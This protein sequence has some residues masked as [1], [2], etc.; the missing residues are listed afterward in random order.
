KVKVEV[1]DRL[2]RLAPAVADEAI[3]GEA[4]VA[5][6]RRRAGHELSQKG[7]V[8]GGVEEV[9]VVRFWHQEDVDGR[10]RVD[11]FEGQEAIVLEDLLAGNLIRRDLAEQTG[12]IAH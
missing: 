5:G 2:A 6:D 10:L 1:E 3:V 9:D 11:V 8:L 12:G 7:R 4:A